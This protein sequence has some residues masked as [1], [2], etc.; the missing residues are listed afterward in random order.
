[1]GLAHPFNNYSP[2]MAAQL[3]YWGKRAQ[4]HFRAFLTRHRA[5]HGL[6][7][8]KLRFD[9][10]ASSAGADHQRSTADWCEPDLSG[11]RTSAGQVKSTRPAQ[12]QCWRGSE[13]NGRFV[14]VGG[15]HRANLGS[16]P[17]GGQ[18]LRLSLPY[19]ALGRKDPFAPWGASRPRRLCRHDRRKCTAFRWRCDTPLFALACQPIAKARNSPQALPILLNFTHGPRA[20]LH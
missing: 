1:M 5:A 2:F 20:R 3:T 11:V 6:A 12:T 7:W 9:N 18:A 14:V 15:A 8:R 10:K 16:H 4:G 13:G 17:D 19:C